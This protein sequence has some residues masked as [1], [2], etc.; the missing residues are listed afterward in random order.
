MGMHLLAG[1]DLVEG[2]D[3]GRQARA[4]HQGGGQSSVRR[5]LFPSQRDWPADLTGR[6]IMVGPDYEI[7]GLVSDA[8]YPSPREPV[9]PTFYEVNTMLYFV[10][11]VRARLRPESIIQ[12]V[13]KTLAARD[14]SL[15]FLEIHTLAEEADASA[16]ARAQYRD[17]GVAVWGNCRTACRSWNLW[18][19]G[20]RGGADAAR[21]RNSHGARRAAVSTSRD[22]LRG[23]PWEWRRSASQRSTRDHGGGTFGAV[24][25]VWDFALGPGVLDSGRSVCCDRRGGC[26]GDSGRT[27]GSH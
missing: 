9:Y 11:N 3:P 25:L 2:D 19:A 4:S 27:G 7:I 8:K 6:E 24:A 14:P 5:A 20:V 21:D 13:Q 15:A 12:P 16:L 22:S 10:L 23:R 17:A 26:H 1:R 18:T